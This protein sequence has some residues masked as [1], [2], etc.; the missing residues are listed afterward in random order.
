[1]VGM[2]QAALRVP[3]VAV[4]GPPVLQPVLQCGCLE[5]TDEVWLYLL[6]CRVLLPL[7]PGMLCQGQLTGLL[8]GRKKGLAQLWC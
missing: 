2:L 5:G 8:L 4:A 7:L 6:L 1:M 3:Q